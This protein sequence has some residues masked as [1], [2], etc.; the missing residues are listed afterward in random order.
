[1]H[2]NMVPDAVDCRIQASAPR[3]TAGTCSPFDGIPHGTV[4]RTARYPARH[5]IPHGM[6]FTRSTVAL[7][8]ASSTRTWQLRDGSTVTCGIAVPAPAALPFPA[9]HDACV[10]ALPRRERVRAPQTIQD[11][12]RVQAWAGAWAGAKAWAGGEQKRWNNGALG[13][14]R[15]VSAAWAENQTNHPPR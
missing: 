14:L 1:M 7:L 8:R 10:I 12:G 11:G 6:G 15:K 9:V 2:A 3:R 5:V 13:R 4:S